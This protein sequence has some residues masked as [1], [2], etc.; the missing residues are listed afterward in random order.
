MSALRLLTV[1]LALLFSASAAVAQVAEGW[2][3]EAGRGGPAQQTI[4]PPPPQQPI[5]G[6]GEGQKRD[7]IFEGITPE[8]ITVSYTHLTLPTTE[9]V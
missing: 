2:D 7:P 3:E 4:L 5:P 1:A 8:T 6:L 9:R